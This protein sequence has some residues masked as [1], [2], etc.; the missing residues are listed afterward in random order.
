MISKW[1]LITCISITSVFGDSETNPEKEKKIKLALSIQ[2]L[3]STILDASRDAAFDSNYGVLVT[4]SPYSEAEL[5]SFF[6]K[7]NENGDLVRTLDEVRRNSAATA[8]G[9]KA[10]AD[11]YAAAE[12]AVQTAAYA[13]AKIT[14]KISTQNAIETSSKAYAQTAAQAAAYAKAKKEKTTVPLAVIR[15]TQSAVQTALNSQIT[16]KNSFRDAEQKRLVSRTIIWKVQ[17]IVRTA[18][19]EAAKESA[20]KSAATAREAKSIEDTFREVSADVFAKGVWDEIFRPTVL[21]SILSQIDAIPLHPLHSPNWIEV[22][23]SFLQAFQKLDSRTIREISA[24]YQF[25]SELNWKGSLSLDQPKSLTSL[26]EDYSYFSL[27]P[28]EMMTIV[29]QYV[30]PTEFI[31]PRILQKLAKKP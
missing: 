22:Q 19:R 26:Y 9:E 30:L 1:I 31:I 29:D 21:D 2:A 27:V 3:L 25:A 4:P 17:N 11:S 13:E 12:A 18:V 10:I 6:A 8:A 20:W 24:L 5:N 16:A 7:M 14:A 15:A 23:N 28:R